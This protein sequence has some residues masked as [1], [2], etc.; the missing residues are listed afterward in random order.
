MRRVLMAAVLL[1][2][3][4]SGSAPDAGPY[5]RVCDG[6]QDCPPPFACVHFAGGAY[7]TCELPC[8]TGADCGILPGLAECNW[9][10]LE[11]DPDGAF[12]CLGGG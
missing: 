1:G 6:A 2:C 12:F 8:E 11:D 9:V 3:S 5:G 4:G 7:Q 10:A